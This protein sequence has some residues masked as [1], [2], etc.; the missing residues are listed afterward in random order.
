MKK[1]FN[2][3]SDYCTM[4]SMSFMAMHFS[5]EYETLLYNANVV[6]SR[7]GILSHIMKM[8]DLVVSGH[9]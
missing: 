2:P 3:M 7:K 9:Y 5:R 1:V 4:M 6:L 8:R